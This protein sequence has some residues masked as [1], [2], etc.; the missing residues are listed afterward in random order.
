MSYEAA[1]TQAGG[2]VPI[3]G[4]VWKSA[5]LFI[6]K[7]PTGSGVTLPLSAVECMSE[8]QLLAA[9]LNRQS[10][11]HKQFYANQ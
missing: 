6:W 4:P 9:I 8:E 3:G 7:A 10:E 11:H 1:I 2:M 5:G